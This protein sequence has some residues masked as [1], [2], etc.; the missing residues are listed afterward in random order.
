MFK[1]D[2]GIIILNW[3]NGT[4]GI[5]EKVNSEFKIIKKKNIS[6]LMPKNFASQY[7]E[8]MQNFINIGEKTMICSKEYSTFGKDKNNSIIFNKLYL[9]IFLF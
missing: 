2:T 4:E 8:F 3:Y 6:I 7:H 9:K 1:N 5:I